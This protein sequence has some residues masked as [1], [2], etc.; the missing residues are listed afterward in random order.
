MS[1]RG[2]GTGR[3]VRVLT[4]VPAVLLFTS[5]PH[6]VHHTTSKYRLAPAGKGRRSLRSKCDCVPQQD[7]WAENATIIAC[8]I[9]CIIATIIACI[10]ACIFAWAM[11]IVKR[12]HIE[13]LKYNNTVQ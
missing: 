1:L 10:I 2:V 9:A 4:A 6:Q 5:Q 8:I 11:P 7:E 3:G 12:E 13:N